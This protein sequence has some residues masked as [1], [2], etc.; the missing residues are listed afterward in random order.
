MED[1]EAVREMLAVECSKML[2][3]GASQ[4]E[5][6]AF[7]RD[8]GASILESISILTR[9]ANISLAEAKKT[10]HFSQTWTDV[11][12]SAEQMWDETLNGADKDPS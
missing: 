7:L 8:N 2:Q 5:V 4:Y 9:T 3:G 10:V 11:R 12:E 1:R 6:I